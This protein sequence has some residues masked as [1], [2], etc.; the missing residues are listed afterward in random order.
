MLSIGLYTPLPYV[1]NHSF[2]QKTRWYV[3]T[4]VSW[5]L[6]SNEFELH[7]DGLHLSILNEYFSTMSNHSFLMHSFSTPWNLTVFCFQGAENRCTGT[8]GLKVVTDRGYQ[9]TSCSFFHYFHSMICCWNCTHWML[10]H[11][12]LP[13]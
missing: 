12:R 7:Y 2:S 3:K 8:N 1:G 9:R 5:K 6:I 10:L 13:D 11:W 4:I